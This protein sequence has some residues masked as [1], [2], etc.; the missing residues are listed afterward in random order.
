M[1]RRAVPAEVRCEM[2]YRSV[3]EYKLRDGSTGAVLNVWVCAMCKT[4]TANPN[5][6][7]LCPKKDRR[8]AKKERRAA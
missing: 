4:W 8:E 1:T 7:D 3:Y 6:G 5:R 2:V